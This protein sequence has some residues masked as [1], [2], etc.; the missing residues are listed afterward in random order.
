MWPYMSG[1]VAGGRLCRFMENQ[2]RPSVCD[3]VV[4]TSAVSLQLK[5]KPSF[6]YIT[7][8]FQILI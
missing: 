1:G 4:M 6:V 8:S 7:L 2:Y 3:S 5:T